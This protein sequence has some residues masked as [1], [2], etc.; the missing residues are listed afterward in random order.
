MQKV[1]VV[2]GPT[3]TGKTNLAL[4]IAQKFNGEII[5]ADSRQVYKYF[6]VV[7]GKTDYFNEGIKT[8]GIDIVEPVEEFSA[9]LYADYA[10]EKIEEITSRGKLPIIEGGTGFYIDTALKD[11]EKISIPQ[12][13]LLRKK[14]ENLEA[15]ELFDLYKSKYPQK[16]KRLNESDRNNKRR[17]L[18]LLEIGNHTQVSSKKELYDTFWVGLNYTTRAELYRQI[19]KRVEDRLGKKLEEEISFLKK[20]NYFEKAEETTPGYKHWNNPEKW[21]TAEHQYAKRQI[22]WF[23][24]HKIIKWFDAS[25]KNLQKEVEDSLAKWYSK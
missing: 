21:K 1:L 14:Y 15:R 7:T 10:R 5:S 22:T 4:S 16:A 17:L 6:D 24:R 23:K 9:K 13:L 20:N 18:R 8:W 2:C 3:A 25:S 12:N 19:D 11:F